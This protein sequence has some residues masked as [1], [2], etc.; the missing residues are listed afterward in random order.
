M[1]GESQLSSRPQSLIRNDLF[2]QASHKKLIVKK[3]VYAKPHGLWN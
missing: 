2:Y 1:S 3:N